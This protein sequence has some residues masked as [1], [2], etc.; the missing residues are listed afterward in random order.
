M[1]KHI[2]KVFF[3]VDIKSSKIKPIKPMWKFRR[4]IGRYFD[5]PMDKMG[6]LFPDRA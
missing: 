5:S 3:K 4:I 1:F 2:P 6:I